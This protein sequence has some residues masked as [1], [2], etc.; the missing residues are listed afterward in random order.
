[1]NPP[2]VQ[3][4]TLG[5]PYQCN[6]VIYGLM[7]PSGLFHS[8]VFLR[9]ICLVASLSISLLFVTDRGMI[10]FL[11]LGFGWVL[12][13]WLGWYV[14]VCLRQGFS[15]QPLAVPRL[16]LQTRPRTHVDLPASASGVLELKV[17]TITAWPSVF[18]HCN[19]PSEVTSFKKEPRSL[20]PTYC[21]GSPVH[22]GR[23]VW[24]PHDPELKEETEV[25]QFLWLSHPQ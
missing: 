20:Q 7:C 13:C 1:M 4:V 8:A 10:S 5:I 16:T 6:H 21:L 22:H 2:L 14:F 9:I 3:V 18:F 24:L 19:K 12:S 23:R 15:V 25:P 17:F 11:F